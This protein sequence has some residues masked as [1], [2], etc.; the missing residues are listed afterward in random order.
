M[1]HAVR[2]WGFAPEY[3]EGMWRMLQADEPDDYILATGEGHTVAEFCEAAFSH[4]GLDWRDY[5]KYD[6]RY[7]RP[8]E[9][10]ALIGDASKAHKAL[11]LE[12]SDPR[13]GIGPDH[14]RCRH[15]GDGSLLERLPTKP[16]TSALRALLR[17]Q[18]P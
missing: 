4:A 3:V 16:A 8:S 5:V 9:V 17:V 15:R 14:G 18:V 6:E 11:G 12:G 1:S 10:D 2:D 7:E 13:A